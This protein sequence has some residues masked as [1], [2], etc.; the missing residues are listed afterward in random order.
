MTVPLSVKLF[1]TE[2]AVVDPVILS[3]GPLEA[4][5]DAGNLRYI[6]VGGVEALRGVAFLVRDRN[7]GTYNPT[8]SNLVIEQ[9]ETG[10]VVTYDAE[11][12]DED[13]SLHYA[14]RIEGRTDGSLSFSSKGE[15][16]SDFL[17]ARTGFVVLHPLAGIVGMP[18]IVEHTDGRKVESRFP[19]RIDPMCPFQDVRALTHQVAAGVN[20]MCRMEGDAFEMEDHRNWMDASYK[21]YSRPLALPWPF[22]MERGEKFSQQVELSLEGALENISTGQ[23]AAPVGVTVGPPLGHAMPRIGLAAPSAYLGDAIAR[24]DLVRQ[25]APSFLVCHFDARRGD[26]ADTMARFTELGAAVG[27]PLVLEAVVPCL[28][29]EGAPTGDL[30]VMR[31]DLDAVASAVQQ[32]GLRFE[33]V[34]VSPACDLKCTLPGSVFPPAPGWSDLIGAARAVFPD[35]PVGGGMFSYFTELNRKRPPAEILDFLCHSGCPIVHAGDDVSMTETLEALP[36]IFHSARALSGGKPYWIL[37]TAVSMRD[38]PYGAVPAENPDNIRQAMNRVDPRERGLIG[39]AWYAGYIA[40][41][42]AAGLEAITLAAAAGPSGIAYTG[43]PHEQPGFDNNEAAILY[44]HFHVIAGLAAL[45]GEVLAAESSDARAVQA[46]AVKQSGGVSLWLSNLTGEPQSVEISGLDGIGQALVLD[47]HSFS[48]A[49]ADPNWRDSAARVA[50]GSGPV[51][52]D[53]YAVAEI[54]Y[55]AG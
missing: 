32:A 33:R 28:D 26:D 30:A 55:A 52:L 38:N 51:E 2:E 1:G 6:R 11:C 10:F 47:T 50:V 17:T 48:A 29:A 14:A 3:A 13:Q 4:T 44:P 18:V 23:G 45:R 27:A 31:R 19:E 53:A 7:W 12:G 41:A 5:F 43:Q 37:P 9:D 36:S 16:L 25:A 21:T 24:A 46:V 20:L 42:G 54:R 15:T 49:C 35:I 8:L 39:A 34:A 22:T 40:R